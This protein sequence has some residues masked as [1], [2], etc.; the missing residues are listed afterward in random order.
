MK[1]RSGG[2]P[3]ADFE[4]TADGF[5]VINKFD[6]ATGL[7]QGDID[8]R[9]GTVEKVRL[10]VHAAAQNWVILSEIHLRTE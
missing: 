10:A 9:W 3:P 4:R 6:D 5:V 2:V 7:C 1:F 8:M